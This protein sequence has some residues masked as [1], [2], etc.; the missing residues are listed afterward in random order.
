MRPA[1]D[2]E[3]CRSSSGDALPS[4]RKRAGV[5]GRSASTRSSGEQIGPA[6]DLVDARRGRAAARGPAWGPP[7]A[8][9]RPDPRGRRR[10]PA[11][12]GPS[13]CRAP[14]SSCPPGADPGCRRQDASPAAVGGARRRGG[15]GDAYLVFSAVA[16]EIS[17]IGVRRP[18]PRR[19]GPRSIRGGPRGGKRGPDSARLGERGPGLARAVANPRCV[20]RAEG[21]PTCA[22]GRSGS[23]AG[24]G[25]PAGGG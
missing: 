22:A 14:A 13:R 11:S 9:G 24:P 8:P 25:C 5:R 10:P 18:L 19:H 23:A 2:S 21:R 7:A 16:V 1:S 6:L 15:G 12:D 20:A 4:T 3:D 17:R